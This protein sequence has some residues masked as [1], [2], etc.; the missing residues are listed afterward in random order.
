MTHLNLSLTSD[1]GTPGAPL[2]W[3]INA[4]QVIGTGPPVVA[5]LKLEWTVAG[6]PHIETRARLDGDA[7]E[8]WIVDARYGTELDE[9]KIRRDITGVRLTW[10]D[11]DRIGRWEQAVQRIVFSEGPG[12][13]VSSSDPLSSKWGL[14]PFGYW[15]SDHPRLIEP[16]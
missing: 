3:V 11:P 2:V 7:S 1:G 13:V 6:Q 15:Q 12:T 10:S 9:D 8:Y 14:A 5:D 4:P 16:A